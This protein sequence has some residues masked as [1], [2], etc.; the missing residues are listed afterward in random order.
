MPENI[1]T[2]RERGAKTYLPKWE[3]NYDM[4]G[5]W[6]EASK[7]AVPIFSLIFGRWLKSD[8]IRKFI[9]YCSLDW[10]TPHSLFSLLFFSQPIQPFWTAIFWIRPLIMIVKAIL[11]KLLVTILDTHGLSPVCRVI[12]RPSITLTLS[13]N[14]RMFVLLKT[15]QLPSYSHHTNLSLFVYVE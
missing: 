5:K 1:Q 2:L 7:A 14:F 11:I 10:Y 15:K 4:A 13:L 6:Q 3:R 12:T 8:W 9:N